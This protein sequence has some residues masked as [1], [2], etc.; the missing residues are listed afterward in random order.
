LLFSPFLL[1]PNPLAGADMRAAVKERVYRITE[2][3][4]TMLPGTLEEHNLTLHFTPKF[5]DLRDHEYVRYPLELRYGLSDRWELSGGLVPFGPNPFNTGRDHRW[6][7]GEAKFYVRHA[8]GSPLPFFTDTTVGLETRIPVGKPPIELNDHYTHVKP[9]VSAAR[10]FERWPSTTFYTNMSY[11]RSIILTQRGQPPPEVMRRHVI[12]VWPGFLF[13]PSELGYFAEYRFS[14]IEEEVDWHLAHELRFGSIWDVPLERTREWRL[15]GKWQVELAYKV[16][17][18][19]GHETDQ[20]IF[21]RVSW[22]TTL[23]EVLNKATE[24]K[25][26]VVE[27]ASGS[28]AASP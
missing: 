3:F 7:P 19:E 11:D 15:P 26:K 23:R 13:R 20:G 9:F 27:R 16:A 22:Q 2:F 14:H 12:D 21:A 25:D 5:S 10:S 8:L 1:H 18:E 4:D 6:G 24:I 17:H 28:S